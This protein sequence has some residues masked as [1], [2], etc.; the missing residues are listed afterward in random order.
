MKKKY[1]I[2]IL[3]LSMVLNIIPIA[4]AETLGLLGEGTN[5]DSTVEDF[6][7]YYSKEVKEYN[8]LEAITLKSLGVDEET[9]KE[10]LVLE[11]LSFEKG[12]SYS[13]FSAKEYAKAIMGL[14]AAD[15]EIT[16]YQGNNYLDFLV[17]SQTKEGFFETKIG[18]GDKAEDIAYSIIALDMAGAEYDVY[19]AVKL[20]EDKFTVEEE[21]AFVKESSFSSS[22]DL[23][24]T[25]ISLIAISNHQ[26]IID[27]DLIDKTINYIESE[28]FISGMY[29]TTDWSGKEVESGKLTSKMVQALISV[30]QDIPIETINGLLDL[31]SDNRFKESKNSYG[32]YAT[33]EVFAALTD[34]HIEKSM[35]KKVNIGIKS[36][37]TVKIVAPENF[38]GLKLGKRAQLL[39]KA[40]DKNGRYDFSKSYIW[41]SDNTEI[42]TVDER[43]IVAGHKVGTVTITAKIRGYEDIHDSFILEVVGVEPS[44]LDIKIDREISEIEVGRKIGI[45]ADVLDVEGEIVEHANVTWKI[46]PD[47][48]AEIKDGILTALKSGDIKITASVEKNKDRV[49]S[50][51]IDLKI[52]TRQ[53]RIDKALKEVKDGITTNPDKYGYTTAMGLK[54][55]GVD[56][57][58]IAGKASK[59]SYSANTNTRAKDI[60]MAIAIGKDP[61][62]YHD[63]NYIQEILNSNFYDGENSEWLA[64]AIIALDMAGVDY[65]E[66]KAVN[67]LVN[68]LVKTSDRYYIEGSQ[69]NPNNELTSL[70]LIALS[71]HG[72]MEGVAGVIEGIKN[73]LKFMQ[74]ENALI[75]NCKSHSFA[76]QGLIAS[77][78][79]IYSDEWTRE[80]RYGNRVTVLDA[81]LSLKVGDKFKVLPDNEWPKNGEE[82]Y[83]FAALVDLSKNKSMY[84]ELAN[85]KPRDFT[86][87]IQ[88]ESKELTINQGE[89]I[90]L[91]AK[92]SENGQSVNKEVIWESLDE[93]IVEVQDGTIKAL[94]EGQAKVRVK[95]R[96]FE[97]I[98][99]EITITVKKV[100]G[101]PEKIIIKELAD[102]PVIKGSKF[103]LNATVLDANGNELEGNEIEWTS[104][105]LAIISVD[106]DGNA[107]AHKTGSVDVI[108]KI[109]DTGIEDKITIV[110]FE[111]KEE[112][113]NTLDR[114]IDT[115]KNYYETIHY[116]ESQGSLDAWETATLTRAGMDLDKWYAN[117]NYD[118]KY[119]KNLDYL[120]SKVNQALIMLDLG[121]NPTKFRDRNLI[122]EIVQE[123][124]RAD[125]GHGNQNYLK[126]VIAVDRFNEK[127]EDQKISY[128]EDI[129]INNILLA[130]TEEGGFKERG[131][132]P[133][134]LNTG[135]AL[136][137][138]SRHRSFNGVEDSVTKAIEYLQS[139]QQNDGG[140]YIGAYI[141]GY[142]AEIIS[143]LLSIGEDLTNAKWTK[144][145][146]NPIESMFI[147][148]KDNGSFDNKEGESENNR[149]WVAATQKA[150]YTLVDLKETGYS[151]YVVK[152]KILS[153]NPEEPEETLD[154]YT[155]IVVDKGENYDIKSAPQQVTIST[156]AH[157]AGLTALGSLQATTPLHT[158]IGGYVKEIFG[159][160]AKGTGGWIYAVND[161]MPD[162]NPDKVNLKEGDKIVWFF[163]SKGMDGKIPTWAELTG[164]DL[165][166][167]ISIEI[168]SDREEVEVGGEIL[169]S[170]KIIRN[171]EVLTDKEITWSS[172]DGEIA[173][174]DENGKLT[175]H[176]V[177]MVSIVAA[178]KEDENI[179]ST[180]NLRVVD[181]DNKDFKIETLEKETLING[182]QKS[183]KYKIINLADDVKEVRFN[184]GLYDKKTDKL[185]NHSLI[186]R[187]F[188]PKEEIEVETIFLIPASGDYYIK[189]S[190]SNI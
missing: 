137:A 102:T 117:K 67:A 92:V 124:D 169:L 105:D 86:I 16:D 147:L 64:N 7:K 115:V 40:Y 175:A 139:I 41:L 76:I 37:T 48:S 97:D 72:N 160:E 22:G 81:L 107:T 144:E 8:Y 35:F 158:A 104:S 180:I 119:D 155:A 176:K 146:K 46:S 122:E 34:I 143:G 26:D 31:R 13:D 61:K 153:D 84:H 114:F 53:E 150:L 167:I 59:Y 185:I 68:K 50:D 179:K 149:G 80:D 165:G 120:A 6:K 170:A 47:D 10:K 118:S 4:N 71:K 128:N 126:A 69:G 181:K 74:N 157:N 111:D 70:T 172:S 182:R 186:E 54:L 65:N 33:G 88:K 103:K 135:Y 140:F 110:V 162:V 154:V 190:I 98:Y 95:V 85:E 145:G 109:K 94:K 152:S 188:S 177:G 131:E 56:E 51:S 166:K 43:G 161:K 130:Q 159:I 163:S 2:L 3:V 23:E 184:I 148:W 108:V 79:D 9:I 78:E 93:N 112:S 73:H 66:S 39:A 101:K 32:S 171:A 174:V 132:D 49:L 5:L 138:L 141:T 14:I 91:E 82:V 127:Y 168:I 133:I 44:S 136:N 123:I 12:N 183:L 90:E 17:K 19:K 18:S 42:A 58:H 63:K 62:D 52:V 106:K 89:T 30:G 45:S 99:D 134:P 15:F 125:Y 142:N 27:I 187:R 189:K 116:R 173:T 113:D 29:G 38:K 60:M 100:I 164:E 24:L 129:V 20:L 28:C 1:L 36:P 121:E 83:G 25:A 178:L 11:N 77:G 96:F 151:N 156:K 21:N 75:G 57:D 87:E 55:M